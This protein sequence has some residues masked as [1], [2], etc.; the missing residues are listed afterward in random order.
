MLQFQYGFVEDTQDPKKLGRVRVRIHGLHSPDLAVLPKEDLKWSR[1]ANSAN[2]SSGSNGQG[3]STTALEVGDL[4]VGFFLDGAMSQEFF[5]C[6]TISGIPKENVNNTFT[7]DASEIGKPDLNQLARGDGGDVVA[8]RDSNTS[9]V[10]MNGMTWKEPDSGY[11]AKY[12]HNKVYST[13][14]GHVMEFDDTPESERINVQHKS[15]SYNTMLPNGDVARKAVNAVY[16]VSASR[17]TSTSGS[18]STAAGT[19]YDSFGSQDVIVSGGYTLTAG[20]TVLDSI[21]NVTKGLRATSISANSIVSDGIAQLSSAHAQIASKLGGYSSNQSVSVNSR[22]ASFVEKTYSPSTPVVSHDAPEDTSK[23]WVTLEGSIK[24]FSNEEGDWIGSGMSFDGDISGFDMSNFVFSDI[25]PKELTDGLVWVDK[26]GEQVREYVA[27]TGE[28]IDAGIKLL[29]NP[30]EDII[31]SVEDVADN[32]MNVVNY[33]S[34]LNNVV[35]NLTPV[36]DI[37]VDIQNL[38]IG[39]LVK[40]TALDC[41]YRVVEDKTNEFANTLE[42]IPITQLNMYRLSRNGIALLDAIPDTTQNVLENIINVRGVMYTK[43]NDT[44]VE[45]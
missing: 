33:V 5:V 6:F 22:S 27:S 4:V 16:D 2:V 17:N 37:A 28:W 34:G 9:N 21:V 35:Q 24:S 44:W 39:D 26:L 3:W 20:N 18:H 19:K 30:V 7:H 40:D 31:Q 43:N 25:V 15:G 45:L 38:Q 11:N 1:I 10:A 23:T 12:P 13:K 8:G 14:S 29:V 41:L 42:Q 36:F 32:F